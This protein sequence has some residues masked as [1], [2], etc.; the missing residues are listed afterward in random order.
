MH[1][2]GQVSVNSA[3]FIKSYLVKRQEKRKRFSRQ[4][5]KGHGG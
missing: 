5:T 4:N 2:K 1:L 3:K